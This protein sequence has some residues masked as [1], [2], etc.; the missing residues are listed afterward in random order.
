[1]LVFRC[2]SFV[3]NW[4][5]FLSKALTIFRLAKNTC[6]QQK[7]IHFVGS[8]NHKIAIQPGHRDEGNR[9]MGFGLFMSIRDFPAARDLNPEQAYTFE[10]RNTPCKY[11][12]KPSTGL[13]LKKKNTLE[14][15][16]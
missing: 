3:D 12:F 15:M 1:V 6:H 13:Q 14:N 9:Q 11:H 8:T 4:F 5:D 2:H 10:K 16:V 7:R